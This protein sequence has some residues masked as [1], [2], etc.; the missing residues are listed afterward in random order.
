VPL[1][2]A[3]QN[4][5]ETPE[6]TGPRRRLPTLLSVAALAFGSLGIAACGEDE[7]AGP[8]S[9]GGGA[10]GADVAEEEPAQGATGA[11]GEVTL[12]ELLE[13]PTRYVGQQ[14]TVSGQVTDADVDREEA[15]LAAFTLGEGVDEDLLV[16]PTQ[17]VDVPASEITDESVLRV[18]GTVREVDEALADEGNFLFED[19]DDAF[20]GDFADQVAIAATQIDTN[21]PRTDASGDE[22][23][24]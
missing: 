16:L 18:Q 9:A 1:D 10:G 5:C 14:V 8:E 7:S 19:G 20:L 3:Y 23:A 12:S 15:S 6:S 4:T 21:I 24:E 22:P 17:Q 13:N 2:D 11:R